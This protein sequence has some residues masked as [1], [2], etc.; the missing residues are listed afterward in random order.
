MST[1]STITVRTADNERKSIYCHWDGYPENNGAIL[2]EFYNDHETA[3][4]L[5]EHGYLSALR[6]KIKPDQS[7]P[8]S[9]DNAQSDVCIYYGRDRGETGVETEILKNSES[10]REEEFNYYFDG[11]NWFVKPYGGRRRILSRKLCGL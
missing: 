4:Q 2:L 3:K 8:H 6:P 11:A 7:K 10:P 5:V 9:F 1:N